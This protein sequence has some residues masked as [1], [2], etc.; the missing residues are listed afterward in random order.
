MK[1]NQSPL[2][3]LQN[4][5]YKELEREGFKD[6]EYSNNERSLK[7]LHSVRFRSDWCETRKIK[8]ENYYQ[9]VDHFINHADFNEICILMTKHGNSRITAVQAALIIELHSHGLTERHIAE[10]MSRGKKC[11][12]LT[13]QKARAWMRIL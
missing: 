1:L 10:K 4:I 9:S 2:K 8:N 6:I 7:E 3:Y 5:W 11:I 12:H 13:I